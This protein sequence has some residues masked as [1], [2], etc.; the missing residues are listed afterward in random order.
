MREVENCLTAASCEL[1]S[2]EYLG[3]LGYIR[4]DLLTVRAIDTIDHSTTPTSIQWSIHG[5]RV[6][7]F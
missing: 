3:F 6:R 7:L 5:A 2:M 4:D 1:Y